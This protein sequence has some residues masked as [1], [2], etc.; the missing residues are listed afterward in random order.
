MNKHNLLPAFLAVLA[1]V[2]YALS[3]PFSRILLQSVQPAM[4]ASMLYLGAG[5]GVGLL[6]FMRK[7]REPVSEKLDR[8]DLPYV[9][10]MVALDILAPILLMLG[11]KST[12]SATASL[13]NNFEIVATSLI[14]LLLFKEL[15][16]RRL[17]L[18]ILLIT[19]SSLLLSFEGAGAL[20]FSP[21]A[22]LVLLAAACWGLENNCTRRLSDKNT[23][24]I[25]TIKGIFSGL[26]A[27]LVALMSGEHLPSLTSALPTLLLGFV[28]FGLSIF[29][30]IRAQK[31]L[32]A[33]KTSAYY[34]IA[35][36]VGALLSY[37]VLR[38]PLSSLYLPALLLML[39]GTW[40]L[41]KDTLSLNQAQ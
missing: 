34:A 4:M 24:Q 3:I 39:L 9:L 22:L 10:G 27:M 25:V 1:A 21:G 16:S 36:F 19:L 31:D 41:I 15:I 40:L 28:A 7:K 33:A 12:P 26:G 30:Y 17:W 18:A 20:R 14:A 38:E 23:Y 32:G 6:Y 29:F 11:L 2:F 35:P 37:A 5:I 13:L 8:K